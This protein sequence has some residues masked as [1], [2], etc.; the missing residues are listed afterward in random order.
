MKKKIIISILMMLMLLI[1]NNTFASEYKIIN[2][3]IDAMI[4]IGGGLNVKELIILDGK[5]DYL[6]R[7][8]NYYSFGDNFWDG[9]LKV[10]Y[11]GNEFYNGYN[12]SLS[13]VAVY[14]YNGQ[15]D[16]NSLKPDNAEI[17]KEFNLEKPT[18]KGY[19]F[20]DNKKG[21]VDLKVLY[22][23]DGKYAIY[24]NYTVGN[25]VVK[26]NDIKEMNYS[27]KNLNYDCNNTIVRVI[28]P[29]PVEK[30]HMD[31]YNVWVHGNQNGLFQELEEDSEDFDE[32]DM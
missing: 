21:I 1:P 27:F 8:L 26:H 13:E 7:K 30:D 18:K 17:L 3:V 12:L 20:K 24:I 4:E 16:I 9:K 32:D 19:S 31:L 22:P 15:I 14:K 25:A 10:D 23:F 11:E 5:S 28:T 2:H 6:N 29:Y